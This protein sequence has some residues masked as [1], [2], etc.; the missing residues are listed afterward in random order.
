MYALLPPPPPRIC[1]PGLVPLNDQRQG[2]LKESAEKGCKNGLWT[3]GHDLQGCLTELGNL[4]LRHSGSRR[5][6]A[7]MHYHD[8]WRINSQVSQ[9]R[10]GQ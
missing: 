5:H 9:V 4:T 3:V 6:P 10:V 2:S 7:E 8:I 1:C